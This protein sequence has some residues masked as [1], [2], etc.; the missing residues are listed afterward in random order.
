MFA[1]SKKPAKHIDAGLRYRGMSRSAFPWNQNG[2]WDGKFHEHSWC[3]DSGYGP[4]EFSNS[5]CTGSV[6]IYGVNFD[7]DVQII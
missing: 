4:R 7:L 3:D 1:G 2:S 6:G 5:N